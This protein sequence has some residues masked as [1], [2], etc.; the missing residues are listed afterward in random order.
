VQQLEGSRI[1]AGHVT[2]KLARGGKLSVSN[3]TGPI[4]IVG[5]DRD[6]IEA[7]ASDGSE[8]VGIRVYQSPTRPVVVL[9]ISSVEGRRFS[10]EATL[11]L[12]I[13]RYADV[14]IVDSRDGDI[15]VS[16]VDGSVA[17]GSRSGAVTVSRVGSLEIR[18]QQGEIKAKEIKGAFSARSSHGEISVQTVGGPVEVATTH[19]EVTVQNAAGDVRVNSS[20]SEINITC[21]KG[22]VEAQTASG[23]IA[24]AGIGGDVDA[25]TASGEIIFKGPIRAEGRYRLKSL[26]GEVQMAIQEN[27]PGFTATLVTYNGEI[28][29]VFRLKISPPISGGPINRR[30]TGVYGDGSAHLALDSF[31]GAVRIVRLGPDAAKQQCK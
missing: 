28:E 23:S 22:R 8:P 21:A 29:T 26:S 14:E 27:P 5:S 10:G 18:T 25:S 17:I 11:D 3:N 1:E 7:R 6:T 15:E 16:E 2:L 9:S 20:S 13:P 30:I 4:T 24:L 12:K 31:N 19:G